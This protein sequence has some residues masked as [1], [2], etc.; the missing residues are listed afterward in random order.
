M[1]LEFDKEIDAMMRKADDGRGVL[2]GDPT[3]KDHL[4]ADVIAAFAEYALPEKTRQFYS[5]HLADCRSCRKQ[6]SQTVLMNSERGGEA[7]STVVVPATA[8]II[9]W[10]QKLLSTPKLVLTMGG[11]ILAFSGVL[12]Y[13]VVQ[14]TNSSMDSSVAKITEN[15]PNAAPTSVA[16]NSTFSGI[17]NSDLSA[18]APANIPVQT[19]QSPVTGGDTSATGTV[20]TQ[21]DGASSISPGSGFGSRRG[22]DQSIATNED[23]LAVPTA[24]AAPPP[25]L[26][27]GSTVDSALARRDENK[28]TKERPSADDKD[29]SALKRSAPDVSGAESGI[30]QPPA[31]SVSSAKP[32]A[33]SRNKIA[34]AETELSELSATR[35]VNGKTFDRRGDVWY[36][37]AYRGQPTKNIKRGSDRFEKLD[38]G[39]Q[40]IANSLSGTVVVVWK[41]DAFRIQ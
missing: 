40:N 17:S 4:D 9:P 37:V 10:Y 28:L 1:E 14:N 2:V 8:P 27:S 24:G 30:A 23:R 6:L 36:D 32:E 16:A 21:N 12:G 3:P 5:Q 20:A 33:M 7:A 25:P 41:K 22:Q 19:A 29:T 35:S 26:P 11:L 18:A 39:L 15:Q 38:K 34:R 31:K 13:L